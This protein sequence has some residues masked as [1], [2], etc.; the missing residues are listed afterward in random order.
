MELMSTASLAN[1]DWP[2]VAAA[3]G[4]LIA[5]VWLSIK[6]IQKGKEKVESGGSEITSIVGASL[7]E[8]SS[9]KILSEQL[10]D[11]TA[12]LQDKA[13]ALREN[14]A[15]LQRNTDILILTHRDR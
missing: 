7:I 15:A 1:V 2:T 10:R 14:T 8:S 3:V 11:N 13:R 5:T 9:V 6:G 4:T 12:A